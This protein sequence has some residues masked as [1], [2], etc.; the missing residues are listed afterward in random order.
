[1][2]PRLVVVP[3]LLLSLCGTAAGAARFPDVSWDWYK[4]GEVYLAYRTPSPEL[5]TRYFRKA[6]EAGNP[7]A[8]YKLGEH[9]EKG[10]GVPRSYREAYRWYRT[11][12][13]TGDRYAEF[14]VGEFLENG[15]GTRR[16]LAEA[17][18]W[19]ERAARQGNPW[20]YHM[21]GFMLAEGKGVP[22]DE[23][24]AARYLEISVRETG[25]DWAKWRLA[26]LIRRS[27][28]ARAMRLLDEAAASGNREARR[29][30]AAMR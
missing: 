28:P 24:L 4:A 29:D 6:A 12:A 14:K 13:E 8:Q 11:A 18:R 9:Y 15:R 7:S 27:D 19:Y 3:L 25:D 21:L 10:I 2:R 1:M 17:A 22:R 5:S 23:R 20:G 16:N 30:L 26:K